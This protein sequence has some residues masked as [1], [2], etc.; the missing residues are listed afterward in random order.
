M[1]EEEKW[2]AKVATKERKALA[3]ENRLEIEMKRV[4]LEAEE[5]LKE[6]ELEKAVHGS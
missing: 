2:K 4:A 5:R 1:M 6:I 3:E